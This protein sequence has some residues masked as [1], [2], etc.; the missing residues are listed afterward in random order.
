M[1][2][3]IVHVYIYIFFSLQCGTYGILICC[4]ADH[5]NFPIGNDIELCHFIGIVRSQNFS[6]GLPKLA[7]FY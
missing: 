1:I 6:P 5:D 2:L 7:K 3:G 4:K